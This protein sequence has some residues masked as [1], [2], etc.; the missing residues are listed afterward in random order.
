MAE[1]DG[2]AVANLG[3]SSFA[4]G[5]CGG[6]GGFGGDGD[7]RCWRCEDSERDGVPFLEHQVLQYL[8]RSA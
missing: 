5:G 1:G 8:T 2:S 4:D 3:G 6:G 7:G